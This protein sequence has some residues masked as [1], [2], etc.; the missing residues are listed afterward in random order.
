MQKNEMAELEQTSTSEPKIDSV[1]IGGTTF[2]GI[3]AKSF[4]IGMV[5]GVIVTS[6]AITFINGFIGS[7][8]LFGA[9]PRAPTVPKVRVFDANTKQAQYLQGSHYELRQG[10]EY[11]IFVENYEQGADLK[12]ALYPDDFGTLSPDPSKISADFTAPTITVT[13][14]TK[15]GNGGFLEVCQLDDSLICQAL[16]SHRLE[17]VVKN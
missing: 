13:S 12:W 16:S 3:Q 1:N 11:H 10:Q 8:G 4:F 15:Y 14:T 6:I 2:R 17:F 7:G 9:T 5:W